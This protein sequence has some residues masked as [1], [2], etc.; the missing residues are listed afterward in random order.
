MIISSTSLG[1]Y[2]ES[3]SYST[4]TLL[5]IT[6]LISYCMSESEHDCWDWDV[7]CASRAP[8]TVGHVHMCSCITDRRQEEGDGAFKD[9][10][11][12]IYLWQKLIHLFCGFLL[13]TVMLHSV[14][15]GPRYIWTRRWLAIHKNKKRQNILLKF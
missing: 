6:Q 1:L 7:P 13:F 10:C 2:K 4:G 3:G 12:C 14:A 9:C 5:W 8:V 15:L 11:Y